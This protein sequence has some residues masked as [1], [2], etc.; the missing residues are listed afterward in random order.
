MHKEQYKIGQADELISMNE[1][2]KSVLDEYGVDYKL[3]QATTLPLRL[4]KYIENGIAKLKDINCY[5]YKNVNGFELFYSDCTGNEYSN[6]K[7]HIG[8][9]CGMAKTLATS[10]EFAFAIA[11]L[12]DEFSESFNVVASYSGMDFTVSFYCK[13]NT[14]EWLADDLDSYAEE[15]I[16]VITT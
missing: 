11:G 14:E 1:N 13:R 8:V 7:V 9:E 15:A 2:M 4:S 3:L 5:T 6:N 16:F 12:L 10:L